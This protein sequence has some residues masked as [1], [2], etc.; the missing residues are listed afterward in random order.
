[1]ADEDSHLA[2]VEAASLDGVLLIER[3]PLLNFWGSAFELP[4][5]HRDG[6]RTYRTVEHRFQAMKSTCA[7]FPPGAP[8]VGVAAN[9]EMIHDR[10]AD[11]YRAADA[12]REGRSLLINVPDWGFCAY[13][14]MFEAVAQKFSTHADLRAMLLETGFKKLVEHRPDPVWG[15]AMDGTGQNLMGKILEQVRGLLS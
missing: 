8:M 15:D 10:V 2:A 5:P 14:V 6:K 1:M 9:R 11:V 4:H 3:G 7:I 12:K 13:A